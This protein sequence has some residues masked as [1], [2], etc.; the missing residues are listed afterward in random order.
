MITTMLSDD[1]SHTLFNDVINDTYHSRLGAVTESKHVF[2]KNGLFALIEKGVTEINILEVGFGTGL[3][4]LLT[5]QETGLPKFDHLKINYHTFETEPLSPEI[6]GKLNYPI[7][8]IGVAGVIFSLIHNDKW[9]VPFQ[10]TTNLN[11]TK[12]KLPIQQAE[13]I[14]DK[15]PAFNLIY[16]DAF[17]PNNQPEMWETPVF[18]LLYGLS[19]PECRLVTYCAKSQVKRNLKAA[20][21]KVSTAPGP[22][23]KREMIIAEKIA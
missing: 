21:F 6:L 3:N 8:V 9:G 14:K 22:P 7:V 17:A 11:F 20:D 1:G 4:A 13:T 19:G 15:L 2:L 16:Y 12:W 23:R 18:E 5:I 10:V